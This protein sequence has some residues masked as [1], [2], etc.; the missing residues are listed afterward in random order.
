M[1]DIFR[2]VLRDSHL[3]MLKDLEPERASDHLFQ[4][5]AFND[6]DCE[7]VKNA[8]T[9]RER[10][11]VFLDTLRRGGDEAYYVFLEAL[12]KESMSH[13]AKKLRCLEAYPFCYLL[14]HSYV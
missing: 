6:D 11:K 12:E 1:K 8:G 10:C 5:G 9:R 13:L 14:R 2:R 4:S 7:H 3:D